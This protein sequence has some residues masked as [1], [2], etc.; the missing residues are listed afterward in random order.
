MELTRRTFGRLI[1]LAALG[2]AAG[3]R[4]AARALAP[5]RVLRAARARVFPGR[6][7]PLVHSQVAQ[8]GRW[9]G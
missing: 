2:G 4:R 7:R 6:V 1:A 9:Q 8:R 5:R 3:F